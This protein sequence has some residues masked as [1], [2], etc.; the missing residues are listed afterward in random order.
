MHV[1]LSNDASKPQT[2]I[3]KMPMPIYWLALLYSHFK[4]D[5]SLQG[6]QLLILFFFNFTGKTKDLKLHNLRNLWDAY[7]A[8]RK[9]TWQ[10]LIT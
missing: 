7:S 10:K 3:D 5:N 2:D 6:I 9:F 1:F 8:A 4:T